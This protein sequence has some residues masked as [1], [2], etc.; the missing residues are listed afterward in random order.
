LAL[1]PWIKKS[2]QKIGGLSS[3]GDR[4]RFLRALRYAVH[5]DGSAPPKVYTPR[6]IEHLT[7]INIS[8]QHRFY[9]ALDRQ[10]ASRF[11]ASLNSKP[12]PEAFRKRLSAENYKKKFKKGSPARVGNSF[13]FT[14]QEILSLE[15]LTFTIEV[16]DDIGTRG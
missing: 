9:I 6:E 14:H 4:R 7:K 10:K 16:P 3:E 12:S 1:N 13:V 15:E 8:T 5:G 2:I 11:L